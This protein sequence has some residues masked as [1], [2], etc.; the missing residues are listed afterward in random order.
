MWCQMFS[1]NFTKV[2]R[3]HFSLILCNDVFT[4]F[5]DILACLFSKIPIYGITP[6]Y[7]FMVMI[8]TH[9]KSAPL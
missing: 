5:H 8:P 4:N 2:V 7:D 3:A 6:S 9:V 1:K